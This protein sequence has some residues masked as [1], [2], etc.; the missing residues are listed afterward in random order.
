MLQHIAI[1]MDGNGRWAEAKG[2]PRSYGHTQGAKAV[3]RVVV[4]AAKKKLKYL[5]LF[6]FSTENWKR[7][8]K[9]LDVLVKL[10]GRYLD[11]ETRTMMQ[12]N[13]RLCYIGHIEKFGLNVQQKLE[14][15]VEETRTNKGMTLTLALNYGS[16]QELQLAMQKITRDV[17]LKK[18]KIEDMKEDL[19]DCYLETYFL[20]HPDIIIRTGGEKRLSNFLLWQ[21]SYAELFFLKKHWPSFSGKDLTQVIDLYYKRKRRFGAIKER[22]IFTR[23]SLQA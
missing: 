18:I 14:K 19:I 9:E 10:L 8:K 17:L 7:P 15:S 12:N 6:A 13:I 11:R 2:Y 16:K 1:I 22:N 21:C 5:T 3:R 20:P 23:R 4:A